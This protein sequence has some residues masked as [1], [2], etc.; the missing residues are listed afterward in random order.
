MDLPEAILAMSRAALDLHQPGL[1]V[2]R[3]LGD[4]L[5]DAPDGA[6]DSIDRYLTFSHDELTVNVGV[7][8]RPDCRQLLIAVTPETFTEVRPVRRGSGTGYR[9]VLPATPLTIPP[10]VTSLEF[11]RP[12]DGAVVRTAWL[13]L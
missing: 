9:R 8:V 6:S 10:G 12:V 3:L 4:S 13:L 7:M 11:R 1:A 2:A 5:L